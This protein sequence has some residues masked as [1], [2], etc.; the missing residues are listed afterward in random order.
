MSSDSLI[1]ISTIIIVC[2]M[3]FSVF[4]VWRTDHVR[5]QEFTDSITSSS[6]RIVNAVERVTSG[7]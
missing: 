3:V 5:W 6:L 1:K 4:Y 2:F 7:E